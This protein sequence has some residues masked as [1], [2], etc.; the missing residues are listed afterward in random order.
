MIKIY[1]KK[2]IIVL[3][4][5]LS[6]FLLS[7][8]Q[9]A[10]IDDSINGSIDDPTIEEDKFL[11]IWITIPGF[12]ELNNFEET[13]YLLFFK[14]RLDSSYGPYYS[15][16]NGKGLIRSQVRVSEKE[17]YIETNIYI[18]TSILQM[19]YVNSVYEGEDGYYNKPNLG[20]SL[21]C[22]QEYS[23]ELSQE[24]IV[25]DEVIHDFTCKVNIY[26]IHALLKT[27][28]SEFNNC[29]EVINVIE[30]TEDED[31]DFNV[32]NNTEYV[33]ITEYYQDSDAT[34]TKRYIYNRNLHSENQLHLLM[35]SNQ[36]G[37]VD[38]NYINIKF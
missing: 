19:I 30:I 6:L 28:I 31:I 37:F 36:Y 20:V 32:N 10:K 21:F 12:D 5:M 26:T 14:K 7:A 15:Y 1:L 34:Y 29:D 3:F 18:N 22:G 23:K 11:G 33:I 25:D 16:T 38:G 9:L 35:F 4:F 24:I 13:E 27:T 8:C 2:T 17:E